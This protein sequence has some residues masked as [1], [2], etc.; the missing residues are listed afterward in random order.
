MGLV[1][2]TQVGFAL[3]APTTA[4]SFIVVYRGQQLP[5]RPVF[6]NAFNEVIKKPHRA[7]IALW[8]GQLLPYGINVNGVNA[9]T[10]S[11]NWSGASSKLS[12][13]VLGKG[14]AA[15]L[16]LPDRRHSLTSTI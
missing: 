1:Q 8:P 5:Y 4:F 2:D 16:R 9:S 10:A 11:A 12:L 15:R 13:T 3:L 14:A 6:V 7:T